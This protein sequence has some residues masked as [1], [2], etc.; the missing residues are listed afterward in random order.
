MIYKSRRFG[1][2]SN[3]SICANKSVANCYQLTF[4]IFSIVAMAVGTLSCINAMM[5]HGQP[6]FTIK[7][8]KNRAFKNLY[9][10]ATFDI[11]SGNI[12]DCLEHCLENCHC[13]SFQICGDTTCQLCSSHKE[14]NRLLLYERNGC[15]YATYEL[16]HLTE[17][18][19][20]KINAD[21]FESSVFFIW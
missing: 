19:P 3:Y 21:Y 1:Y 14:D 17:T 20:V 8:E 5:F 11:Q 2:L 18:F 15:T 4:A 10:L 9:L 16:R 7:A 6:Q 12:A 13:Q